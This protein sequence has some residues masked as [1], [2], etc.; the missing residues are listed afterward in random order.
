MRGKERTK[1]ERY[2]GRRDM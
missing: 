2:I 1:R